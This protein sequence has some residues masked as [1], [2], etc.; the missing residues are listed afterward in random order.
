MTS[1]VNDCTNIQTGDTTSH[2][3][4]TAALVASSTGPSQTD[5]VHFSAAHGLSSER[6]H[7]PLHTYSNLKLVIHIKTEIQSYT[8][9]DSIAHTRR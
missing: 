7:G 2:L 1:F 3:F 9:L 5:P 4:T 6:V 8:T